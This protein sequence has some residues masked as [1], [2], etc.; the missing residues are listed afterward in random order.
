MADQPP[1]RPARSGRAARRGRWHSPG[2]P[3]VYLA[4][5]SASAMLEMLVHLEL[6]VFPRHYPLLQI[7]IPEPA[8]LL[9]A[10]ISALPDDWREQ[11]QLTR[12]IGDA[13]LEQTPSALLQ[14][15]SALTVDGSNYL[16]NPAHPAASACRIVSVQ[17]PPLDPRLSPRR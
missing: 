6:D 15:P 16:L 14:V 10:D 9:H 8:S 1:C 4:D 17:A 3:V 7:D 12:R 5:H 11:P 13:W 2:R